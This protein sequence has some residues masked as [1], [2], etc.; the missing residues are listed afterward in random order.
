MTGATEGQ[1]RASQTRGQPVVSAD[2]KYPQTTGFT[3]EADVIIANRPKTRLGKTFGHNC[4][5]ETQGERGPLYEFKPGAEIGRLELDEYLSRD[6]IK[7]LTEKI[8][9]ETE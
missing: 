6:G 4:V 1:T 2:I 5:V 3:A 8:G 9:K 7:T